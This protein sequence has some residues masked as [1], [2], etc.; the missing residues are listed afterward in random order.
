MTNP[1][2]SIM[3]EA[4]RGS[5]PNKKSQHQI[6]V[7]A[8]PPA[9]SVHGAVVGHATCIMLACTSGHALF[10]KLVDDRFL[11]VLLGSGAQSEGHGQ[12]RMHLLILLQDL[13]VLWR[14]RVELLHPE[15]ARAPQLTNRDVRCGSKSHSA[16][17]HVWC[18]YQIIVNHI[19]RFDFGVK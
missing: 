8:Q 1:I 14:A 5:S 7:P 13:I 19:A 15:T 9:E 16:K 10:S 12:Q 17:C 11:Q 4:Q 3:D 18:L 6:V 2:W